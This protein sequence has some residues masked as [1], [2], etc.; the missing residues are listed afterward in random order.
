MISRKPESQVKDAIQAI[1]NQIRVSLR[2]ESVE[3]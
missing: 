2:S 3:K 1:E